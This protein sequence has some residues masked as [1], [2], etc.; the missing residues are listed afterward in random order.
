MRQLWTNE[1]SRRLILIALAV[2]L[3]VAVAGRSVID[4]RAARVQELKDRYETKHMEYER[5]ARLLANRDMYVKM[6][7]ELDNVEKGVV[8]TRFLTA[9]SIALAEVRFQDLVDAVARKNGLA[10][11]SRKMLKVVDTGDLK[12]MRVAISCRTEIGTLN[13][14]LY[15]IISSKDAALFVE[16]MDIKRL[17]DSEER[18]YNFNA[19]LKAYSL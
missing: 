7:A 3:A 17:G 16:S 13:D 9:Q 8:D 6:Q 4:Y 14:F 11:I 1:A 12:E 2:L 10:I 15:D 19:V 18:F 5:Y